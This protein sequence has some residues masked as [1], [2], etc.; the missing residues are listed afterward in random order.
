MFDDLFEDWVAWEGDAECLTFDEPVLKKS[1]GRWP[2]GH[3]FGAVVF[4]L[5]RGTMEVY[6]YGEG[7]DARPLHTFHLNLEVIA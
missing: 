1:L 5:L 2:A 7:E 3:Q 6:D 4:D